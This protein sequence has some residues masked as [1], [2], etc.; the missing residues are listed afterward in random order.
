MFSPT[1]PSG[2]YCSDVCRTQAERRQFRSHYYKRKAED[3][4]FNR[5]RAARAAA[6]FT[7]EQLERRSEARRRHRERAKQDPERVDAARRYGREW[8]R[9]W[10]AVIA[11]D[12]V[13]AEAYRSERREATR[14]YQREWR[15]R[16][17][18][19]LTDE[20]REALRLAARE[21][22]REAAVAELFSIQARMEKRDEP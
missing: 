5:K 10:R 12:P 11:A 4:A 1:S 15:Q 20:E 6:A 17:R 14:A 19:A 3:P 2:R 22:R 18:A 13:W 8:K 21:R 16:W 9:A 7:P